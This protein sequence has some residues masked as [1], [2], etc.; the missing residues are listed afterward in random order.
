MDGTTGLDPLTN[1]VGLECAPVVDSHV[2]H[3]VARCKHNGSGHLGFN[4]MIG[5]RWLMTKAII[6]TLT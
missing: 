4:E 6:W 1:E 3:D 5:P 2:H